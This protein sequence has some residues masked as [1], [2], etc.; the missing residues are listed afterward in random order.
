MIYLSI[1]VSVIN[2]SNQVAD[3]EIW[4]L[5]CL[6]YNVGLTKKQK[7]KNDHK[8]FMGSRMFVFFAGLF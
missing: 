2:L 7:K 1:L 4:T 6:T 3:P 8:F 5:G